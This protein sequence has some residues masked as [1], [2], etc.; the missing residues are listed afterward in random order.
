VF[1]KRETRKIGGGGGISYK[2]SVYVPDDGGRTC[3]EAK[4]AVQ[5][6]ETYGG[7]VF[8]WHGGRAVKLKK[9]ERRPLAA[10]AK[11]ECAPKGK[12]PYTPSPGH[13]WR[14]GGKKRNAREGQMDADRM[15]AKA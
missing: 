3:L 9:L 6:R 5:V 2:N 11:A 13:P 4:T 15:Y 12:K 14:R 1:A 10:Q 7:D 8:L